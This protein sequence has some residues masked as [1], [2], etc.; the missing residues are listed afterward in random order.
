MVGK[1][2]LTFKNKN[3]KE[4]IKNS[5]KKIFKWNCKSK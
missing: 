3:V 5:L 1:D 4:K 2:K